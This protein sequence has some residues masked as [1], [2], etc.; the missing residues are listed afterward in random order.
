MDEVIDKL[1]VSKPTLMQKIIKSIAGLRKGGK[2]STLEQRYT[3]LLNQIKIK[4]EMT[5]RQV[6]LAS[7]YNFDNPKYSRKTLEKNYY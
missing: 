1:L 6:L 7:S 5:L 3:S 2:V 4:N